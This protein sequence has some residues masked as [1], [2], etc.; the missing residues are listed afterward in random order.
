MPF[1]PGSPFI[2]SGKTN[3]DVVQQT[4]VAA[5]GAIVLAKTWR[6]AGYADVEVRNSSGDILTA[7]KFRQSIMNKY[8]F[9]A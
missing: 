4:R 8:K 9:K 5:A 3:N 2:I 1:D 7:E 6:E